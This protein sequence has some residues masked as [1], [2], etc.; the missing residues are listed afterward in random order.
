M[1]APGSTSSPIEQLATLAGAPPRYLHRFAAIGD[2][3]PIADLDTIADYGATPLLTL[4]PWTAGLG[5]DQPRYALARIAAGDFDADLTR[6]GTELMSWHKPVLLRWAQEMNGTWYPWSIGVNGNTAADYRAAWTR[7]RSVI[8]SAGATNLEFVWAPNVLTLG[9]SGFNAAYPGPD[10][11]DHLGLDGYN[12][13]DVPGHRWQS[14][15]ELFVGSISGGGLGV[16]RQR[17]IVTGL[18]E[19]LC[20]HDRRVDT[21]RRV[22]SATVKEIPRHRLRVDVRSRRRSPTVSRSHPLPCRAPT[23]MPRVSACTSG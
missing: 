9:T 5:V 22:R 14:A 1:P 21:D 12:W 15:S 18:S 13:G 16:G 11:V 6:W 10:Q 23:P 2:S 19:D 7:M 20:R 4:E 3:V 8:L 17:L